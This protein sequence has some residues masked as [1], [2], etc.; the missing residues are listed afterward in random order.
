MDCKHEIAT[1]I[2]RERVA[3]LREAGYSL[4]LGDAGGWLWQLSSTNCQNFPPP[5]PPFHILTWVFALQT[6]YLEEGPLKSLYVDTHPIQSP[7]GHTSGVVSSSDLS[8]I[9]VA[10]S[11][12]RLGYAGFRRALRGMGTLIWMPCATFS[13]GQKVR[14]VTD[15]VVSPQ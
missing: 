6:F 3:V 5:P 4:S 8:Q 7:G 14:G 2:L 10:N 13:L 1:V 11:C 12:E 9:L 15:D